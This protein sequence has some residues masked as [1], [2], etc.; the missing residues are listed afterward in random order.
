MTLYLTKPQFNKLADISAD[1]AQV[2]FA[3]VAIPYVLDTF[4]PVLALFGVAT[5]IF[6]WFLSLAFSNSHP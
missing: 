3:S 5:A 6:F 2:F 1:I 4:R